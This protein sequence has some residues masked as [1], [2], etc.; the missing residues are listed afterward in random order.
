MNMNY[1]N[2]ILTRLLDKYEKSKFY[3]DKNKLNRRILLKLNSSEFPEYD[4]ENTEVKEHINSV[5][6]ELY[7]NGLSNMNG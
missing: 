6:D 7:R 2:L 1:K 5:I 3:L 4:I